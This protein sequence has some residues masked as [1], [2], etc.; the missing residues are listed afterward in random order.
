MLWAV[1]SRPDRLEAIEECLPT[2]SSPSL[3]YLSGYMKPDEL[4]QECPMRI[5][6]DGVFELEGKDVVWL[7]EVREAGHLPMGYKIFKHEAQRTLSE[8]LGDALQSLYGRRQL[9]RPSAAAPTPFSIDIRKLA[10]D[11]HAR[12]NDYEAGTKATTARIVFVA[13]LDVPEVQTSASTSQVFSDPGQYV[14]E[15]TDGSK[16]W[17]RGEELACIGLYFIGVDAISDKKAEEY[18]SLAG[19]GLF[20]Y[21]FDKI[22]LGPLNLSGLYVSYGVLLPGCTKSWK[23]W[24]FGLYDFL[25]FRVL[26]PVRFADTGVDTG[27]S[28]QAFYPEIEED[29]LKVSVSTERLID[30]VLTRSYVNKAGKSRAYRREPEVLAAWRLDQEK[31]PLSR[32]SGEFFLLTSGQPGNP[33]VAILLGFP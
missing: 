6:P 12:F 32:D 5:T 26:W 22:P 7:P 11:P 33:Y 13:I 31:V 30:I 20:A 27:V 25:G 4:P 15:K 17:M 10:A 18:R 24:F 14:V 3:A 28:S 16:A 29:A 23:R 8:E 21:N 19:E 9:P 1:V 2:V